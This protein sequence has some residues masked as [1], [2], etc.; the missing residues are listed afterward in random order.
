[1]RDKI[2]VVIIGP[3]KK[4]LS[5]VSYFT[6]RL[7]NALSDAT[8]VETI[9]FRKMLPKRLFPGWKR[10]GEELTTQTFDKRVKVYE[11]LDWYNPV[12]WMSAFRIAKEAEVMIF[13]WWTSSVAHMY[14]VLELLNLRRRP[15]IIEFHEVVDPLESSLLPI[16]IYS[17]LMGKVIRRLATHYVVHSNSDRELISK[18]YGIETENIEVI[19]HGIYDHYQRIERN[20]AKATAGIK[21]EFVILFFGL[22]RSYKGVKYLIKAFESLPEDLV[23]RS[24]LLIVGEMWEDKESNELANGSRFRNKITVV[25]R[26]VSDD[27]IPLYFSASDVLVVPYTRASQSGVAHIGMTFGIPIIASEVGGL[28]ESLGKYGGT[29][30]VQPESA[31]EI[32][33]AL[34]SVFDERWREFEPPEE[35]RWNEIAKKWFKLIDV[36]RE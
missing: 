23:E 30:F 2:K 17:K 20:V 28:K 15:I 29:T 22:L 24:R 26:Y 11:L 3:S 25:D 14:L 9:L 12:T 16:R 32:T 4:F 6:I 34:M 5:G 7:S 19:P 1:M 21:E 36:V 35:L 10:V 31:E 18:N 27:E 13:Q 33:K 8:D